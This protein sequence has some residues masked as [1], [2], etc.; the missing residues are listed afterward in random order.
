M[1]VSRLVELN[2]AYDHTTRYLLSRW[3]ALGLYTA[4]L[5]VLT[6]W[7]QKRKDVQ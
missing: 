5:T 2:Y 1:A 6:C 3:A 7:L 4:G